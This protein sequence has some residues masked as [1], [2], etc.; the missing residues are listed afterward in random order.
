MTHNP[1][2]IVRLLY[3]VQKNTIINT[4]LHPVS[5]RVLPSYRIVW[6]LA[7]IKVK[8]LAVAV[9]GYFELNSRTA[10]AYSSVAFFS[11]SLR[12][13]G[14]RASAFFSASRTFCT[15]V[16]A[17]LTS[18]IVDMGLLLFPLCCS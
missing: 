8:A 6:H 18:S 12:R 10:L 15:L 5:A 11:S 16:S 2:S 14:S 9:A 4:G 17:A 7:P 3:G 1:A 13:F